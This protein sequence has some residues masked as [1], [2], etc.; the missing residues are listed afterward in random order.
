MPTNLLTFV[1]PEQREIPVPLCAQPGD[2]FERVDIID[3]SLSFAGVYA[4]AFFTV[5]VGEVWDRHPHVVLIEGEPFIGSIRFLDA[6]RVEFQS[7]HQVYSGTYLLHELKVLGPIV[8]MHPLG[9]NGP[10]WPLLSNPA[11]A[12]SLDH[13]YLRPLLRIG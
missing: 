4:G 2:N 1:A 8:D 13:P 3:D 7:W 5:L 10:R 12:R 9:E 11:A 6:C